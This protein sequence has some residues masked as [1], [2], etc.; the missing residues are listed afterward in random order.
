MQGTTVCNK[1]GG[2]AAIG[3]RDR[4]L[5]H[6]R[7]AQSLPPD[8][9]KRVEEL[10]QDPDLLRIEGEIALA[11]AMFERYLKRHAVAEPTSEHIGDVLLHVDRLTRLIERRE[12]IEVSRGAL[13]PRSVLGAIA[14]IAE[15][16]A[17]IIAEFVPSE[18]QHEARSQLRA[19]VAEIEAGG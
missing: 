18:L 5:K 7:Y 19:R 10:E 6:G 3:N 11:R 15:C 1:H 8:I 16:C 17:N 12:A 14:R 4:E 2:M 13:T 9:L